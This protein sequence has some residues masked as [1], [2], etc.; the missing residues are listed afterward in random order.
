MILAASKKNTRHMAAVNDETTSEN[1]VK[2]RQDRIIKI[3][4]DVLRQV[5]LTREAYARLNAIIY[6][7]IK[8]IPCE[9]G[10]TTDEFI[11]EYYDVVMNRSVRRWG[12]SHLELLKKCGKEKS[13]IERKIQKLKVRAGNGD[14]ESVAAGSLLAKM[15]K[16]RNA[17]CGRV[18]FIM[19]RFF[20]IRNLELKAILGTTEMIYNVSGGTIPEDLVCDSK[21]VLNDI[22]TLDKNVLALASRGR[23]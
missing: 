10:M 20:E 15:Y 17:I 7:S 22:I 14:A 5:E 19:R 8:N 6:G 21:Y 16:S 23:K 11:A 4:Y 9:Y 2:K 13:D 1:K 18:S 3:C 12:C